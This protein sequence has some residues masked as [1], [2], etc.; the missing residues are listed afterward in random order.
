MATEIDGA[1][2]VAF[3][4]D[5]IVTMLLFVIRYY[6]QMLVMVK[7]SVAS[8]PILLSKNPDSGPPNSKPI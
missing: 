2:E 3:V 1:L 5:C 6:L 7:V 8:L 4:L